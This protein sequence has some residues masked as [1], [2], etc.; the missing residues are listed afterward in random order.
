M[1]AIIFRALSSGPSHRST[2]P[3]QT[4]A[5]SRSS[6]VSCSTRVASDSLSMSG[7]T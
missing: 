6:V 4:T 5:A 3:F 1:F 7:L 2:I